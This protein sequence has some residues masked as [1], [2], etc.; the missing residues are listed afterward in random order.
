[1][2]AVIRVSAFCSL[3]NA[4]R[5]LRGRIDNLMQQTLW[6]RGELEIICVNSGSTDGTGR[7]LR[8][9]V[10]QG[11]PLT[12]ITSL[13]EPIYS[14]WNRAIRIA[15]GEYVTNANADD[16]L[17]KDALELL[18]YELDDYSDVVYADSIVTDTVNATWEQFHK[19]TKPPYTTGEQVWG[20]FSL[21]KL[22]RSCCIGACPMWRKSLHEQYGYFDESF[23][24]AAD[25]EMWLRLASNGKCFDNIG[26]FLSLNYYGDNMTPLNQAQSDLEAR[27]AQLR[28][29]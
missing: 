14:S 1:V 23:L 17:A 8:E 7:I 6:E 28:W 5:F 13:R 2:V 26:G 24:L 19:S 22:K 12:I 18:A 10:E 20:D 27:R 25:Y 29:R 15:K 3:Y 11:V 16:R 4:E 9:Y 21:D